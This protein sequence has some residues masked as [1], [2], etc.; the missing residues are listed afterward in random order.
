MVSEQ[1][2]ENILGE[3]A[4]EAAGSEGEAGD[5]LRTEEH[6]EDEQSECED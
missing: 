4:S 3:G 6:C 5:N 1:G 2:G